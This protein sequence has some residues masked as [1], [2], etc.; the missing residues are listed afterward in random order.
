MSEITA[1]M[2]CEDRFCPLE[3]L[4]KMVVSNFIEFA[5]ESDLMR[6][7]AEISSPKSGVNKENVV[8]HIRNKYGYTQERR[9]RIVW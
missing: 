1:M 5:T 7:A 6:L 9:R 2:W 3:K 8:D 4:R